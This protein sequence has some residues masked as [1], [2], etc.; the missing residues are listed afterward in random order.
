MQHHALYRQ[1][2][3]ELWN[4]SPQAADSLVTDDFVGHWP[5]REV[6]GPEE[7]AA[8]IAET[9]GM[10]TELSFTL[11]V[12]PITEG[13]LVAGRWTGSGRGTDGVVLR[14]IGHD[15][16]RVRDGRFAEYWVASWAGVPSS[17]STGN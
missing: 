11:D 5:D 14:F 2:L 3:D 6:R 12:G 15:L 10:F 16:L 1:W 8:T 17:G 9:H 7:L 13:D 4:G